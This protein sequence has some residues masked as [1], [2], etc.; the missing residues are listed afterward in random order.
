MFVFTK[1]FPE[2]AKKIERLKTALSPV[3]PIVQYQQKVGLLF[4]NVIKGLNKKI[5][6]QKTMAG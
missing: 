1:L 3:N 4:E 2:F 6:I 5:W